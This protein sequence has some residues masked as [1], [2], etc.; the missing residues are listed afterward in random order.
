[1]QRKT[2]ITIVSIIGA[3]ILIPIVVFFLV[4][5]S[6]S[7]FK[8]GRASSSSAVSIM[9]SMQNAVAPT[10]TK[11]FSGTVGVAVNEDIANTKKIV[12][13]QGSTTGGETAAE[14]DQK[15]IKTGYL[16]LVVD[17]VDETVVKI[18]ALASGKGGYIQSSSVY[19]RENGTKYGTVAI[20]IPATEFENSLT[21]I[22]KLATA[23]NTESASGQDVTEQYTDLEARLKNAQAQETE[24]LEILKKAVT[25]NDILAVQSYLGET[26]GQ[27]ESLQGQIK[28][29]SNLTSYSTITVSLSEEPTINLPTKEFRPWT[30]VKEAAQSL[31]AVAQTLFITLIWLVILGGGIFLP[32]I[33]GLVIIVLVIKKVWHKISNQK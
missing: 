33:I 11:N 6:L 2:K 1:M 8:N 23:I 27:I 17:A 9:G 16:D 21:D 13:D 10:M 22:K 3:I 26:R 32:I 7:L 30:A 12:F 24:Y 28:Y 20:R 31:V 18:T 5:V 15:I 19:E 4:T 29:L 25:V 14:V